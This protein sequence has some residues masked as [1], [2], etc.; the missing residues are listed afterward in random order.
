MALGTVRSVLVQ[1]SGLAGGLGGATERGTRVGQGRGACQGTSSPGLGQ[2]DCRVS[3]V[4]WRGWRAR[5]I[6]QR[7]K[8][9]KGGWGQGDL[10]EILFGSSKSAP[11][12]HYRCPQG[13]GSGEG[14]RS[15]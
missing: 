5:A 3:C 4:W 14:P 1:E 13:A 12:A 6:K 11:E 10:Q 9:T 7:W 15:S 8:E 2:G